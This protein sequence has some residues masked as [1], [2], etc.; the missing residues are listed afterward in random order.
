MD[1]TRIIINNMDLSTSAETLQTT[2]VRGFTVVKAPKGPKTPIYLPKNSAAKMKDIFGVSSKDFPE[3]FE[4]ETFNTGYDLYV[5]APY[6]SATV[7]V[8]YITNKGILP[9]AAPIEYSD[10]IE[11]YVLGKSLNAPSGLYPNNSEGVDLLI[12]LKDA[13][14]IVNES[15]LEISEDYIKYVATET[16]KTLEITLPESIATALDT[17]APTTG[18]SSD[19]GEEVTVAENDDS[20]EIK[21]LRLENLPKDLSSING[22]N[23]TFEGDKV[24]CD[25][26]EIGTLVGNVITITSSDLSSSIEAA[27]GTQANNPKDIIVYVVYQITDNVLDDTENVNIHGVIFPKFPGAGPLHLKFT[28]NSSATD[29]YSKNLVKITAWEEGAFHNASS[30]VIIS[31]SLDEFARDGFGTV[32]GFG[33]TNASYVGQDLVG[34]HVRKPFTEKSQPSISNFPSITLYGGSKII[35]KD[36]VCSWD[37]AKSEEFSDVDIFFAPSTSIDNSFFGLAEYHELAGFIFNKSVD[38]L[39]LPTSAL[40][41]GNRYWNICNEAVV[42]YNYNKFYSPLTGTRA[43]MQ[44]RIIDE[45]FGGVAPMYLNTVGLGGQLSVLPGARILGLRYTYDKHAQKTLDTLNYNPVIKDSTYGVMVVGQKTCVSGLTSDWSYIGHVSAF[46]KFQKE[47]KNNVMIPQLGKA[48]NDYYRNLRKQ[49]VEALLEKRIT[50][51]NRI[52]AAAKVDTSTADGVNDAQ[53]RR[54]RKFVINVMVKVDVF[55]EYVELNF[56]NVDQDYSL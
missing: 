51:N 46:L 44:A 37:A 54:E 41:H 33:S 14:F 26:K 29:L 10:E 56:T 13:G 5:S 49:Q 19:S 50:G 47:V 40:N 16:N 11:E 52:W 45:R 1:S 53:A 31:G 35:D 12:P 48:N 8:A 4:A 55:S 30:P 38:P 39:N 43:L 6:D 36:T 32:I 3:L 34:I 2:P 17:Q 27:Y 22:K 25:S 21:V 28:S 24:K 15:S 20:V 7:P 18:D 23:I 42:E 9:A